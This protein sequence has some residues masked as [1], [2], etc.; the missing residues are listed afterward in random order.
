MRN[1]CSLFLICY[2]F[3][4]N[5][6]ELFNNPKSQKGYLQSYR[7]KKPAGKLVINIGQ[8]VIEGYSGDE[9]IFSVTG[10]ENK[11]NKRAEGLQSINGSGL[12]DNTGLGINVYENKGLME[13]TAINVMAEKKIKILVPESVIV[14]FKH[15]SQYAG[16]VLLKDMRNEIEIA[17]TYDDVKLENITGPV[18]A[19]SIHGNID[20]V[21]SSNVRGPISIISIYGHADVSLP[22]SIKA[23]VKASTMYGHIY[24]SPQLNL[25]V[26]TSNVKNP[27]QVINEVN[28][29]INGGGQKIDIRSD[30]GNIYLRA[31]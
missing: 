23:D 19:K 5:A 29:R 7:I 14:S 13:V 24:L 9:V 28:G 26:V 25:T 8:A 31:N 21:F 30:H 15:Q 3:F 22:E 27:P 2:S 6:Q 16:T 11:I 10:N 12:V 1:L 17:T 4:I 18:T 20:A